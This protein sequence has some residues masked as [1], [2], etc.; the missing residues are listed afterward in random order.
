MITIDKIDYNIKQIHTIVDFNLKSYTKK[1]LYC[2]VD[3]IDNISLD[4]MNSPGDNK[5]PRLFYRAK[6]MRI[7]ALQEE[8]DYNY[9]EYEN[10]KEIL[11][12]WRNLYKN[13]QLFVH[14]GNEIFNNIRNTC[15]EY[16]NLLM[17]FYYETTMFGLDD[18]NILS[19]NSSHIANLVSECGSETEIKEDKKGKRKYFFTK[20]KN[21]WTTKSK[22][23]WIMGY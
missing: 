7:I 13:P 22:R 9:T 14:E 3:K 8:V 2:L 21:R 12:Y 17:K 11:D 15:L 10:I 20:K 18:K 23:F 6:N 1:V 5:I 16:E 4:G 19:S